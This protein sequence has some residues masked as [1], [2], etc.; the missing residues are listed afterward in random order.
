MPPRVML[1]ACGTLA[2]TIYCWT[3]TGSDSSPQ[4]LGTLIQTAWLGGAVA[5]LLLAVLAGNLPT[6]G[7]VSVW[8]PY[9]LTS[10]I[11]LVLLSLSAALSIALAV[12]TIQGIS[13]A[14]P[15]YS[16]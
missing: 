8:F 12:V 15:H 13:R 4:P 14:N 16:S 1:L 7:S 6:V 9:R 3:A 10:R 5:M 2:L 11:L